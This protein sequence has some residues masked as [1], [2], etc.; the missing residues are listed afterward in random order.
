MF[1]HRY[2][3]HV[4]KVFREKVSDQEV[5]LVG[6]VR[7]VAVARSLY[8]IVRACG[9]DIPD[10]LDLDAPEDLAC[11]DNDIV[12]VAISPRFGY[13][14]SEGCGFAHEGKLGDF[15]AMLAVELSG[16]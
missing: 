3:E 1:H 8:A 9:R 2:R 10:R 6:G 7:A 13:A 14:K 11:A 15:T 12:T 16:V 5:N 4:P